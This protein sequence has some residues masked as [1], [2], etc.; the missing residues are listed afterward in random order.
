VALAVACGDD[1]AAPASTP[2]DA[3][4]PDAATSDVVQGDAPVSTGVE[5]FCMGTLGLYAPAYEECCDETVAPKKYEFDLTFLR[6]ASAGCTEMLGKSVATGRATFV[7]SAAATCT[8]NVSAYVEG[9]TC[10]DVLHSPTNQPADDIF[11]GEPGCSEVIAGA[12][13]ADAP[14]SNDY[15]CVDGLTCIGYTAESD[16]ACKPPPGEAAICGNGI[17]DGSGFVDIFRWGFGTHPRC[18]PGFHCAGTA[19]Q[20]GT[21]KPLVPASGACNDNDDCAEGLRCQVGVCG[22]AGPAPANAPCDRNSD[23]QDR[24]YCKS[25]DGGYVCA[26]REAAGT[27]CKS[28]LGSECQGTC[29]VPDGGSSGSCVAYCGSQ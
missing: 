9:R 13:G 24:H 6:I 11:K 25:V 28:A 3:S 22:T 18:A 8:A 27:P 15:E 16:G 23:C 14:C 5:A 1:A 20:Q 7:A 10:P 26:P 2:P 21:C 4:S 19:L 12:Q 29:L 17:P